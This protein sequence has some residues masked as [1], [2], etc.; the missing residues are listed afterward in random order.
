[1][2]KLELA[3]QY[4]LTMFPE[5]VKDFDNMSLHIQ[6]LPRVAF[7]MAEAMLAE[8]EKRQDKSRPEVLEEWQPDWSQAPD[9][10]NWWAQDK[11]GFCAW[12]KLEPSREQSMC[13]WVVDFS[14][15]GDGFTGS[16][17][18]GYQGDWK[19]SLRKRP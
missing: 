11:S 8:N 1:M 3:Q 12:H 5:A 14:G 17:T 15:G 7:D 18:F 6:N 2:N 10:A 16:P 4:M 19:D 9:W 13:E